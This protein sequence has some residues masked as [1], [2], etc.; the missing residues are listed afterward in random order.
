MQNALPGMLRRPMPATHEGLTVALRN[1]LWNRSLGTRREPQVRADLEAVRALE[2]LQ[3]V[4]DV[5]RV[6][7]AR[8]GE[9]RPVGVANAIERFDEP[10]RH[11][12]AVG[13]RPRSPRRSRV[14]P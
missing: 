13:A 3:V 11:V 2:P 9:G 6:R 1:E 5:V 14:I 4:D 8:I 12:V 10:E 7:L